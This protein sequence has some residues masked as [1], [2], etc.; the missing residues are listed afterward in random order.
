MHTLCTIIALMLVTSGGDPSPVAATTGQ[1]LNAVGRGGPP[2]V[3]PRCT[4]AYTLQGVSKGNATLRNRRG[5]VVDEIEVGA[6][7][8]DCPVVGISV[9]HRE[10]VALVAPVASECLT[11]VSGHGTASASFRHRVKCGCDDGWEWTM[12]NHSPPVRFRVR[13]RPTASCT[14]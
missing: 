10:G 12:T 4:R 14:P 13:V 3:P 1:H 8:A 5:D 9:D 2:A 6:N 11:N 7:A